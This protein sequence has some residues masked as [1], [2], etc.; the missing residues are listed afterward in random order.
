[1]FQ[2]EWQRVEEF[3][4]LLLLGL[5]QEV[6]FRNVFQ[7]ITVKHNK[8]ENPDVIFL[9]SGSVN[10]LLKKGHPPISLAYELKLAKLNSY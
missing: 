10:S 1:M 5:E 2:N 6:V 3:A 8:Y 7:P 4:L 9:P